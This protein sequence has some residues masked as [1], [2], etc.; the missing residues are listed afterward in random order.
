MK[1]AIQLAMWGWWHSGR[2]VSVGPVL[3]SGS[4][5]NSIFVEVV[6]I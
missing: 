6:V 5:G 3:I 2:N 4:V 1:I